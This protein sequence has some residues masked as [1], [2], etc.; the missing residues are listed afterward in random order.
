M[1]ELG[2]DEDYYDEV[3][4]NDVRIDG[5]L[6]DEEDGVYRSTEATPRNRARVTFTNHCDAKNI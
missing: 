6:V 3:Y 1:Q 4:V 2:I 5:E